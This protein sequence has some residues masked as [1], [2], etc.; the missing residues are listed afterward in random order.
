MFTSRSSITATRMCSA[1][2]KHGH[3][4][5]GDENKVT[6]AARHLL[7]VSLSDFLLSGY[8]EAYG[9]HRRAFLATASGDEGEITYHFEM[10]NNSELGLPAG[11]DPAVLAALLHLPIKK[12]GE[13]DIVSFKDDA[14]IEMLG[15]SNVSDT[16]LLIGRAV[17]R[18]FST[19]YYV[20]NT[21]LPRSWILSNR[22]SSYRRLIGS[23][24]IL[25]EQM[26]NK[27]RAKTIITTITLPLNFISNLSVGRKY[28]LN[29]D[30]ETVLYLEQI[31]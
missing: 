13:R 22:Y 16:R 24:E 23:R 9:S 17:E 25:T 30:F 7:G 26:T 4:I 2:K 12:E 15:W 28:F 20:V 6:K 14:I 29:V 3:V 18:Y 1:F 21:Q 8:G 10:V 31:S 5:K 27:P 11:R 19:A